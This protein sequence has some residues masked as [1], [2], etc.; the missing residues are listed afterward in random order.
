[1]Q[2]QLEATKGRTRRRNPPWSKHAPFL[3]HNVLV[4]CSLSK[5]NMLKQSLQVGLAIGL[6]CPSFSHLTMTWIKEFM[7]VKVSNVDS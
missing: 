3:D 6:L 5:E 7:A 2:V 4:L 1:M